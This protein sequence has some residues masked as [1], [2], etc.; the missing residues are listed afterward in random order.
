MSMKNKRGKLAALLAA[1]LMVF[2]GC[3]RSGVGVTI[4]ENDTGTVEISVGINE[5]Y[6]ESMM[7]QEGAE[8]IFGGKETAK[9]TDGDDSYIC[10]VEHKQFKNLDELKTILT[11]LEYDF[12]NLEGTGS[13]MEDAGLD[14]SFDEEDDLWITD[15]DIEKEEAEEDTAD[16]SFIFK[17]VDVVHNTSLIGDNYRLSLVTMP[18]EMNDDELSMIGMDTGDMFKLAVAVTMPGEVTAE[19]AEINGNTATF[20][21]TDLDEEHLLNVESETTDIAGIV[22]VGIAIIVLIVILAVVFTRRK[23]KNNRAFE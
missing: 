16:N 23:P 17:S 19:G 13:V 8:D 10:M 11:E 21:I 5:K 7:A 1:V 2:T 9:L 4:E 14:E 12:A 18:H 6:Y 22:A 20:T 15:D 3:V